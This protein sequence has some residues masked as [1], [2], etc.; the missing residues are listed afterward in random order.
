MKA[1]LIT[2]E[3]IK[4]IEDALEASRPTMAYEHEWNRRNE[5]LAIVKSLK[6]SEPVAYMGS[7]GLGYDKH[8]Y[9][10]IPLYAG[11]QP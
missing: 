9:L 6:V 10:S 1:A 4:V 3:Q 2:E 8:K 7:A 11:E 5:A